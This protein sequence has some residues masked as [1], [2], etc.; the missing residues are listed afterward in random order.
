M[1]RV[2]SFIRYN[3][4][5]EYKMAPLLAIAYATAIRYKLHIIE[6]IPIFFY[7]LIA[8]VIGAIYVSIINDITDLKDDVKCGKTNRMMSV[9]L[10]FQILLIILSTLS[11]VGIL[12]FLS[13]D[14]LSITLY[15]MAWIAFSMYSIPP[16]RLKCRGIWGVIA[17]ACGAHVF[18]FLFFVSGISF[19]KKMNIDWQWF[20]LIGIWS[21]CYGLRGILWH[22]FYDRENDIKAGLNT[23][24]V[25]VEPRSFKKVSYIILFIELVFFS[26]I[27]ASIWKFLPIFFIGVYFILVIC[28]YKILG[29]QMIAFIPPVS[30]NFNIIMVDYYQVVFPLSLLAIFV[31]TDPYVLIL[32]VAHLLLFPRS[33]KWVLRDAVNSLRV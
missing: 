13:M 25:S 12:I 31:T 24:A 32:G 33:I 23:F 3:D 16:F 17:D 26:A 19:L 18:P 15:A 11:A 6:L 7:L 14:K 29:I 9:P 5:W 30:K 4:W 21:M 22:Q 28:R 8:I 2:L 10:F 1:T 27:L 20:T